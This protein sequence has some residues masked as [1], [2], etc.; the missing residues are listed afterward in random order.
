M[1]A[2]SAE[3][4][5]PDGL[6]SD[7]TVVH[8]IPRYPPYLGGAEKVAEALASMRRDARCT[9]VLTSRDA[10]EAADPADDGFVRRFRSLDLANTTIMPGL[11]G[12]L[13]RLP[14]GALIHLHI[15]S[16][17]VPE[18][19]Y[20]AHVLRGT[21][22]IAHL[23]FDLSTS[24]SWAGF[25]LRHVWMPVVLARVLRAAAAV[26]VLTESQREAIASEYGIE[27]ARISAIRNGVDV[28]FFN[29]EARTLHARPRLLFVGRLAAEKN[30]LLLLRALAGISERFETTL[31]GEG[32]LEHELRYQ[33]TDLGLENLHFRGRADGAELRSIYR[34]ADF[35][36]LPSKSEGMSLVLL[37]ALAM[38]LPV[39]ATDLACNRELVVHGEN[40]FLVAP[41]DPAALRT[42]LLELIEEVDRYERMS[43][44]ARKLAD[45]YRWDAVGA[46]FEQIYRRVRG[47]VRR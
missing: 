3:L 5:V 29:D 39:I 17:F 35:L 25:V 1:D 11:A 7:V 37:E 8:V 22:F 41:G 36:V 26:V 47:R 13:L 40:G 6:A 2:R 18:T 45:K 9:L 44:A 24:S 21:R 4:Q 42:A 34:A 19:V 30:L 46:D 16:A 32:P 31:V 20:A 10:H 33:A 23:H 27:P 15:Y 28:S 38:G 43:K 14:R 12:A